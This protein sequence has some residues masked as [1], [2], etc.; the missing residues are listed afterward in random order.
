MHNTHTSNR[1]QNALASD[2]TCVPMR[3]CDMLACRLHRMRSL[4]ALLPHLSLLMRLTEFPITGIVIFH[5][6][7]FYKIYPGFPTSS[8]S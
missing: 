2:M 4:D 1:P 3:S 5:D 6:P 7:S 8:G